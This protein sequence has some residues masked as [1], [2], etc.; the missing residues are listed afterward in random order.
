MKL[1]ESGDQ[2]ILVNVWGKDGKTMFKDNNK[3]K[4]YFG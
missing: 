1:K 4:V 3:V 2:Y